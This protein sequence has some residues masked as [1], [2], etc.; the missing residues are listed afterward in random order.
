MLLADGG[1]GKWAK[2][3]GAIRLVDLCVGQVAKLAGTVGQG[4]R[5]DMFQYETITL[6]VR[7]AGSLEF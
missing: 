6:A 4:D 5:F 7:P 1:D 2:G 3:K